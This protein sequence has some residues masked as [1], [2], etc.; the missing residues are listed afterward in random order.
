MRII[1]PLADR[2][3]LRK[4]PV[5]LLHGA[6]VDTSCYITS[7][8]IQ[9]HPEKYPR[10]E[11]DGP[12]TSSSRS[13]AFALANNGYD[14]FLVGTRG[15]NKKNMYYTMHPNRKYSLNFRPS[16][17]QSTYAKIKRDKYF[18]YGQDDIIEN[19]L[20]PQIDVVRRVTKQKEFIYFSY[21]ISTPYTLAF[22]AQN[23]DYARDVRLYV[24]MA[25]TIAASHKGDAFSKAFWELAVPAEPTRGAGF[26][27]TYSLEPLAKSIVG[28]TSKSEALRYSLVL[29][30]LNLLFGHSPKYQTFLER[31]TLSRIFM[32]HSFKLVQQYG[33]NSASKTLTKFDYG[34]KE[35]M[36]IYNQPTPPVYNV[37]RM[38]VQNYAIVSGTVDAL[39]NPE[40]VERQI[41]RTSTPTPVR[42]IVG[43]QYNHFD[44][45]AGVEVDK[46]INLPLIEM[47]NE[48]T[49]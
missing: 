38:E 7:S 47:F 23:P 31:N 41:A 42:T 33:Q 34:K 39:A 3:Q 24:Q 16:P 29:Q 13:L 22:L 40:T 6:H 18:Q 8:S 43:E 10:T 14:V 5:I 45:I 27:A 11:A 37:S 4:P 2:S 32:P 48:L 26:T 36:K 9:H 19:E 25:P 15:S 44:L 35:N 28:A 20:G 17:L 12:I 21:S 1:N 49:N 30:F 46:V